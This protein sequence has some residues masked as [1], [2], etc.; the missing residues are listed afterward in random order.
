MKIGQHLTLLTNEILLA[1]YVDGDF[2][3]F[4]QLYQR[5][6]GGVYRYL[7]RQV[8]DN[9]VVDDLF[10]DV[11]GNVVKHA[12]NYQQSATFTTWLYTIARNKVIDHVRHLQVVNSV[13]DNDVGS[14]DDVI[15]TVEAFESSVLDPESAYSRVVQAQAIKDCLHKLPHHQLD[16]FLLREE[17]GLSAAAIA[18]V[19]QINLEAAKSRLKACYKNLRTCL[20][21]RLAL[22]EPKSHQANKGEHL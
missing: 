20:N 16:C 13:I 14:S 6:K 3:A 22:A 10:Q 12:S 11:W 5:N 21:L 1:Q 19:V 18:N 8:H 2:T 17:A 7:L 4:E 15:S 9:S